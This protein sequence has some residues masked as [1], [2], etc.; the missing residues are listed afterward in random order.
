MGETLSRKLSERNLEKLRAEESR[1]RNEILN[2]EG[3][4]TLKQ[5][6]QHK[7]L[8]NTLRRED[9]EFTVTNGATSSEGSVYVSKNGALLETRVH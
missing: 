2:G 5:V 9:P 3:Y 8:V 7:Q 6:L 4:P 1:L